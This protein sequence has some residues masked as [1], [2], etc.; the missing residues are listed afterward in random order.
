[1]PL[2]IGV[3]YLLVRELGF[4]EKRKDIYLHLD[5]SGISVQIISAEKPKRVPQILI[6]A[7][8][9]TRR[10]DHKRE[11]LPMGGRGGNE[12]SSSVAAVI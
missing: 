10:R 6:L 4:R 7:L 2:A 11:R 1:M 12:Y 5:L 9:R 8:W 3:G